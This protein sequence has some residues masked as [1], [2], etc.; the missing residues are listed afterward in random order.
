MID[1]IL[2]WDGGY[3][4]GK[5][6]NATSSQDT[7]KPGSESAFV[8]T[9]K[10][11]IIITKKAVIGNPQYPEFAEYTEKV[12]VDTS[13]AIKLEYTYKMLKDVITEF[14][15]SPMLLIMVPLKD[16]V[17]KG[18]KITDNNNRIMLKVIT[19][20][21]NK[22][23]FEQANNCKKLDINTSIGQL[24]IAGID[25]VFLIKDTRAWAKD[26][27]GPG[28]FQLMTY[29]DCYIPYKMKKWEIKQGDTKPTS[30]EIKLPVKKGIVPVL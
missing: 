22:E 5:Q 27:A 1:S 30:F 12:V 9:G 11:S 6:G 20:A 24:S 13:G 25:S 4:E 19:P 10:D 23:S 16:L 3:Y 26:P 28:S 17:D 2:L 15:P 29:N 18:M 8:E 21:Y 14:K 7:E